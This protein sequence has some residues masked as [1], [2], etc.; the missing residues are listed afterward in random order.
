MSHS[1]G[2]ENEMRSTS[3]PEDHASERGAAAALK[4]S[5]QGR[6]FRW[7]AQLAGALGQAVLGLWFA[8]LALLRGAHAGPEVARPVDE[9]IAEAVAAYSSTSQLDPLLQCELDRALVAVVT[10]RV[11]LDQE[12]TVARVLRLAAIR[13]D[14]RLALAAVKALGKTS[15]V[16]DTRLKSFIFATRLMR[17]SDGQEALAE[18]R[19]EPPPQRLVQE[20][21]ET[22]LS[23]V[24]AILRVAAGSQGS[25]HQHLLTSAL[26]VS[27]VECWPESSA[28][29]WREALCEAMLHPTVLPEHQVIAAEI[30]AGMPSSREVAL[31]L[32][33]RLRA[34]REVWSAEQTDRA[35]QLGAR[36]LGKG[37][38]AA[39][40][41]ALRA[42][43]HLATPERGMSILSALVWAPWPVGVEELLTAAEDEG[44]AGWHA[45]V[46]QALQVRLRMP[47]GRDGD[48]S[49]YRRRA[50]DLGLR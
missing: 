19:R 35:W 33:L 14:D 34:G 25:A 36:A 41:Q 45:E 5:E 26:E 30:L 20:R 15:W 1:L 31:Q 48:N 24:I 37:L 22:L 47:S 17:V 13:R 23:Q 12:G 43:L 2:P 16:V 32:L 38:S 28:Q 49:G 46:R 27:D 50:I 42:E 8:S 7:R 18:L 29:R 39:S 21:A 44:L 6:G 9:V 11:A 3:T 40:A 4:S 10:G